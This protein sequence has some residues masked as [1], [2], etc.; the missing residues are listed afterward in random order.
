MKLIPCPL[1]NADFMYT[2]QNAI[3]DN[4]DNSKIYAIY[5]DVLQLMEDDGFINDDSQPGQ[6]QRQSLNFSV[7]L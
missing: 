7:K 4:T 6:E 3:A 1:S 5:S 2:L